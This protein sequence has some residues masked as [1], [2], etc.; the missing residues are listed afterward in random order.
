MKVHQYVCEQC[1]NSFLVG[2][3]SE[4]ENCPFCWANDDFYISDSGTVTFEEESK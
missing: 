3:N 2:I 1:S 4:P